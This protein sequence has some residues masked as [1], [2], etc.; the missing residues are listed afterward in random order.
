[1]FGKARKLPAGPALLSITSGAPLLVAPVY[2]IA[3]GWR[4]RVQRAAAHRAHRRP[5]GGRRRAHR[6]DGRRSSNVRSRRRRRTGTCSSRPGRIHEPRSDVR[7]QCLQEHSVRVALT[8][9]YAWD[10]PGGVQTHVRELAERLLAEG[11]AVTVLAPVRTAAAQAWV[12]AGGGPRGHPVQRVQRAHRPAAVGREP[13][14]GRAP[15]VRPGRRPRARTVHTVDLD[16]GLAGRSR[17]GRGDVPFRCDPIAT[18]RRRGSPL[19]R[20]LV[21]RIVVR[22]AVS[23][24]AAEFARRRI[25][26]DFVIVP[27]GVDVARFARAEADRPRTGHHAAVR[28]P[29]GRAQGVPDRPGGVPP[30]R[31][32]ASTICAWW[33]P[34]TGRTAPRWKGCRRRCAQ[35][36]RML[37]AVPNV[38]LP[39]ISAA[40]DLFLGS[41]VGGESFGV[42]LVEAM[43]AGVPVVASDIPGYREVVARRS[44]RTVWSRL[45]TPDALADAAGRVLRR[46]RR[47]RPG[48]ATPAGPGPRRSIGRSSSQPG[49]T[50]VRTAGPPTI[51]G[52]SRRHRYHRR[53]V[54]RHLGPHRG[55]RRRPARRRA[56]RTTA[57]SHCEPAWTAG[58]RASTCSCV[59]ATT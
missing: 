1:M 48:C 43:A 40:C 58:G 9:P 6:A 4:V 42:V 2:Q 19:L 16:V 18:V 41:A 55:R 22:V 28:R 45:E 24:A 17:A 11:H 30:A 39:P 53:R 36:I 52:R 59:A 54:S 5:P 57:W 15:Q 12:P 21:R 46:P 56:A 35:R 29:P 20:R 51:V 13:D 34:G 27:N 23:E 44:G 31:A 3:D 7:A 33:S 50:D 8:C 26:G 38:D 14:R 49:C 32:P 47:W 10:D 25:G 37:G